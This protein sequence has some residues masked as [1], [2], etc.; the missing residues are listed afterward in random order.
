MSELYEYALQPEHRSSVGDP[1]VFETTVTETG[2]LCVSSGVKTGRSPLDKRI[3]HDRNTK[4][5]S[6]IEIILFLN[7]ILL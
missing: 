7:L 1:S 4:D 5:V 6:I 2:A 3:V